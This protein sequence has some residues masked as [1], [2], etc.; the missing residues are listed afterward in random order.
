M[1][2]QLHSLPESV[3]ASAGL[4]ALALQLQR[5]PGS[6]SS[7]HAL[8]LVGGTHFWSCVKEHTT[9]V[10]KCVC[11]CVLCSS[12]SFS[13]LHT[14]IRF[15][16]LLAST[17][18]LCL[19]AWCK[20]FQCDHFYCSIYTITSHFIRYTLL[21]HGW[22]FFCPQRC[23]NSSWHRFLKYFWS[24]WHDNI[25][26][27]VQ[28]CWLHI[29]DPFCYTTSQSCSIALRFGNCGDHLSKRTVQLKKKKKT[30]WDDFNLA[31]LGVI[32]LEAAIKR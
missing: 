20:V 28:I 21:V 25:I 18:K 15:L 14:N 4:L 10:S 6:L 3:W 30:Y 1:P 31:T 23:L 32:L 22:P 27:F 17:R 13:D 9:Y 16:F 19:L 12:A 8:S 11:T 7:H 2:T 5:V 29:R 24:Y 26:Q